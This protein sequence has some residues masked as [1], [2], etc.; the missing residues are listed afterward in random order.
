MYLYGI[1][2]HDI[3]PMQQH[4]Y[5]KQ[6]TLNDLIFEYE[7]MSQKGT[8]GFYEETVFSQII[9]Y[10]E[11]ESSIDLAL[12]AVDKALSQHFYSTTFYCR[13]AELLAIQKQEAAA[14]SAIQQ[15]EVL[16]P[17]DYEVKLITK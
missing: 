9:D 14:L 4:N 10:Y 5:D 2:N 12:E 8:V 3:L 7:A 11:S 1:K 15:A 16:S 13:K 6:H 17:S